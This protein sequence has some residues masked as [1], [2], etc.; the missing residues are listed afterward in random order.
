MGGSLLKGLWHPDALLPS[1]MFV[2]RLQAPACENAALV[3]QYRLKLASELLC[4]L[5]G[6]PHTAATFQ[7]KLEELSHLDLDS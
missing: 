6:R 1:G 3:P 7:L 5:H 4:K 2:P